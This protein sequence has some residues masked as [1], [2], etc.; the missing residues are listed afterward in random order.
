MF[1]FLR[2]TYSAALPHLQISWKKK[3]SVLFIFFSGAMISE[4]VL[5]TEEQMFE[6]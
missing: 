5:L 1:P 4:E 2:T 6:T 3:K